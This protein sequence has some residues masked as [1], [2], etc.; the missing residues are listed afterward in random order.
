MKIKIIIAFI[1]LI[2]SA[3]AQDT[4]NYVTGPHGGLL[5]SVENYR[6]EVINTYGCITAYLFNSSLTIIPN[7]YLSGTI[8]FYFDNN[9]TLNKYLIPEGTDGFSVDV[10]NANYYYYVIQFRQN[11]KTITTRFNNAWSLADINPKDIK[12]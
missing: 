4:I 1:V 5:K 7:K 2:T 3:R 9:V 6:V 12:K 10:S 11:E 8:M